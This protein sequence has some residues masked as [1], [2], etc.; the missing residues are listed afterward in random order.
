MALDGNSARP[1][2]SEKPND[3]GLIIGRPDTVCARRCHPRKA[4]WEGAVETVLPTLL[5][6]RSRSSG[7]QG[8]QHI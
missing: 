2:V 1:A 3:L 7:P 5:F 4:E 8:S 6:T